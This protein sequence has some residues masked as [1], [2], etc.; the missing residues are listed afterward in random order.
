[1]ASPATVLITGGSG[2]I[3]Q[4]LTQLLQHHGYKVIHL[5]RSAHSG[6]V[7]T[8]QWDIEQGQIDERAIQQADHII[9]LAGAG[10]ADKRWTKARKQVI[11]DSRV[12]S[13]SL[14]AKA[15]RSV[16]HQVKSFISASAIGY[17]GDRNAEWLTEESEP[18]KDGFLEEVCIEWEKAADEV[19][20]EG[21]RTVKI[22]IGVVLAREGGALPKMVQPMRFG[23]AT[24]FG[25]G[26]QYYSWIHVEDLA[27]LFL[28][29]VEQENMQGVYNAVAPNPLTNKAFTKAVRSGLQ[30]TALLLPAPSFALRMALGQLSDAVLY[31]ARVS[32]DKVQKAGFSYKWTSVAEAVRDLYAPSSSH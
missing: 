25:D 4:H 17:Y 19:A 18:G 15:L 20:A 1:M 9:H 21:L 27:R 3:G 14:L 11:L 16:D 12:Q 5:S 7:T 13:T 30:Q 23:L 6:D 10:I 29:A 2:L 22:R 8:Y 32:A 31:S 26:Q 28:F 24:Y